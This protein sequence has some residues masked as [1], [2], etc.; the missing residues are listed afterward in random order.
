MRTI[1]IDDNKVVIGRTT[2]NE[3]REFGFDISDLIECM[4]D[5]YST[6][7]IAC[8]PASDEPYEISS[9][10]VRISNGYLYWTPTSTETS[11]V[12]NDGKFQ[13][14]LTSG[15]QVVNSRIYTFQVNK[16]LEVASE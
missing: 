7:C 11:V 10:Y 13:I 9:D 14:K 4:D 15:T 1:L 8:L 3:A 5:E 2:D 16:S 6:T 12:G